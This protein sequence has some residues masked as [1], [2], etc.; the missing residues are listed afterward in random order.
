MCWHLDPVDPPA[1]TTSRSGNRSTTEAVN[2]IEVLDQPDTITGRRPGYRVPT[3]HTI[4]S[5]RARR[6]QIGAGDPQRS[7]S[8]ITTSERRQ[9]AGGDAAWR[10]H[11]FGGD[12]GVARVD[13]SIDGGNSWQPTQLVPTRGHTGWQWQTQFTLLRAARKL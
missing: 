5:S 2:D 3:R 1:G 4:P 8:F 12:C 10:E 9:R 11:A 7:G 13:L 6:I